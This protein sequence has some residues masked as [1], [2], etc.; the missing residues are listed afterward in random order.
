M[1]EP[2]DLTEAELK[3]VGLKIWLE[4]ERCGI[5]R[6]PGTLLSVEE[7][8]RLIQ[9]CNVEIRPIVEVAL[10]TGTR[11]GELLGLTWEADQGQSYLS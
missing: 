1:D 3:K 8:E 6:T 2:K 11:R 9:C 7:I 4:C 10:H 5:T